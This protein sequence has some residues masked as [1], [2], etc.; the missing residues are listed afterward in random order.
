MKDHTVILRH[1]E[2]YDAAGI[3]LL[4][5]EGMDAL[6]VRPHGRTMV[7]PNVVAAHS[8]AFTHAFTRPEFL[9]GLLAALRER[10]E[11]IDE[12]YVGENSGIKMP[13]RYSFAM[14]RYPAVL[15][16]H[17]A[18]AEYFDEGPQVPFRLRHPDALRELI[19]IPEG[20]ARCDFLVN[21]PKFK[22]HPWTKV[23]FALKNYIGIQDDAQ[24]LIDHDHM[25][26]A[27]IADLQ[28][29]ISPGF[30]AVDAIIAGER[31]MTTPDPY[32]LHLIIMGTNPVAVDVVCTHIVGLDPGQVDHIRLAARRGYGPLSIEEIDIIGDV[33][34]ET[35]R[36]RA[37]DFQLTLEPVEHIFNENSNITA[38]VG[39]PPDTY[40][41]CWG[42]CPGSL[43][44]AME[45]IQTY[46]PHVYDEVRPMHV[47]FGAY[48]GQINAHPGEPV[49][50]MGD[51]ATWKGEVDGASVTVPFLYTPRQDLSPH[52]ATCASVYSS[53]I[54]A[55]SN[56]LRHRDSPVICVRGCPV[57]IWENLLYISWLGKVTNPYLH[58]RATFP[59]AF[60][61][62]ISRA[63]RMRRSLR[64]QPPT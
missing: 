61:W 19:L 56:Y 46:L 11:A 13:T 10:G 52:N 38:Y 45:M 50:F 57:S 29:V 35:A 53:M 40:D 23:T 21:A 1:C 33:S 6:G 47:V 16:K 9:D 25:L 51:C 41:Y 62:A 49:L 39:P 12:L 15:R 34:L 20:V 24:R 64:G 36:N 32:P 58:P 4:I 5:G 17:G 43:F 31:T 3:A 14:A 60:Y 37:G 54:R 8:T 27:K 7:K 30:V 48:Q 28:E 2:S 18:R 26:H 59:F 22:A 42:G 63:A 44:E 55:F